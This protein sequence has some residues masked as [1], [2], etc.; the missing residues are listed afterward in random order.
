MHFSPVFRIPGAVARPTSFPNMSPAFELHMG[1]G[2]Y[3][4]NS[5]VLQP[6]L[7]IEMGLTHSQAVVMTTFG[8][9]L[10]VP[11]SITS[12]FLSDLN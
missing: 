4:Y 8:G 1:L 2:G 9:S 11:Q 5:W 3:G 6:H 10:S 7:G 12:K